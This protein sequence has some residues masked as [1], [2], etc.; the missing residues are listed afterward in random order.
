MFTDV[1]EDCYPTRRHIPE[2][3]MVL[4]Y[5]AHNFMRWTAELTRLRWVTSSKVDL[6]MRFDWWLAALPQV[7]L[8][9]L[10]LHWQ[11]TGPATYNLCAMQKKWEYKKS[12]MYLAFLTQQTDEEW[13]YSFL[14]RVTE[15]TSL[16]FQRVK[17]REY[18][19]QWVR[20][21]KTLKKVPQSLMYARH[22]QRSGD[23]RQGSYTLF[24]FIFKKW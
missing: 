16:H 9:A 24:S 2:F 23:P 6:P 13:W 8:L 12:C 21:W 19:M 20:D 11:Y 18:N 17:K 15:S 10:L 3:S 1:L 22:M 7:T 5:H 4:S 14:S